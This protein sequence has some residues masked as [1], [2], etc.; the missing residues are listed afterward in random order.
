M[1]QLK[2]VY[3]HGVMIVAFGL[4]VFG[5]AI[6]NNGFVF[7]DEDEIVN[8]PVI[9]SLDNVG[10]IF[11]GSTFGNA[12]NTHL[13]GIY[14]RPLMMLSFTLI[15]NYLG[16]DP[17]YFHAFQILI[18]LL[19]ALLFLML[20]RRFVP[21]PW[22]LM[23]ALIFLLHPLNVESVVYVSSLQDPLFTVF[24]LAALNIIA[25]ATKPLSWLQAG[26]LSVLFL[27]G[28]L[29]KETAIVLILATLIF[30][31]IGR[32]HSLIMVA[33]ALVVALA[34]Y[35]ELRLGLA[36][37]DSFREGTTQI[38]RASF[39]T[40]LLTAPLTL[41]M[42]VWQTFYPY[43]LTI[44]QDWVV[45]QT[46]LMHFW[47]P[48]L[49]V[50]ATGA[51]LILY[52]VRRSSEWIWFCLSLS[53]FTMGLN[54]N[55]LVPMDGT[56]SNR[57]YYL[58]SLGLAG[59]LVSA[60]SGVSLSNRAKKS[61]QGIG[62]C[63][64]LAFATLSF[65]R[66]QDWRD[67]FTLYSHDISYLPDSFYLQNN[68]GVELF[69]RGD[70]HSAKEHFERSVELAPHWTINWSNLGAANQRLGD[71][72]KAK[73]CYRRS[74]RNGTYYLAY[75]NYAEILLAE[76]RLEEAQAFLQK[77]ALPRFPASEKLIQYS[78][79]LSK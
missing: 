56:I 12:G 18:H 45:D 61:L 15:W 10:Q 69:R 22:A 20:L 25:A 9:Q 66:A 38:G 42:Y 64:V 76:N 70:V 57:W 26:T 72:E 47:L 54:S 6:L 58:I 33:G 32:R 5:T 4:L 16:S 78:K 13:N 55:I 60:L 30:T 21:A 43:P 67:G 77:E 29:S 1:K 24:C 65:S 35:F 71:M 34:V 17:L 48:L 49:G 11:K 14:Y 74:I 62:L 23:G 53:I 44:T 27:G 68:L 79:G 51:A 28:L 7:D 75:L 63:V 41:W 37:L 8:N 52:A 3:L 73:E 31:A 46:S 59:F 40:R 50:L 39:I 2:E 19:N 36:H